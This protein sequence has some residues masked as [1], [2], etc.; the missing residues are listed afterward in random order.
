MKDWIEISDKNWG[1]VMNKVIEKERVKNKRQDVL[2]FDEFLDKA[3]VILVDNAF[4]FD[5]N[6]W[7]KE[8][9]EEIDE[10]L[11]ESSINNIQQSKFIK[12]TLTPDKVKEIVNKIIVSDFNIVNYWKT[13]QFKKKNNLTDEDL[14]NILRTLTEQDYKTNSI[15]INNSKNEAIIFI[16][17]TNI[18]NL[19]G[20]DLYIK[21]DYD[22]IENSPVIVISFHSKK[23]KLNSSYEVNNKGNDWYS[24]DW[25]LEDEDD[26]ENYEEDDPITPEQ[27]AFANELREFLQSLIDNEEAMM[28]EDNDSELEEKFTSQQSL[29]KH[30]QKHCLANVPRRVST[31]D[32]IYYDFNTI[33]RY[34]KY[35]QRM[36]L[37]FKNGYE[38]HYDF[39]NN[40]YDADEV[41]KKFTTLFEGNRYLFISGIFGLRN[42]RGIVH[43]GIHSFSSDVT[44]NYKGGNT[45]DICIMTQSPKTITL[46]PVDAT[47]LKNEL[48]RIIKKYSNIQITPSSDDKKLLDSY[49]VEDN[50]NS[51]YLNTS[52]IKSNG[53]YSINKGWIKH[54]TQQDIPDINMEE[55]EK[56]FKVWE[57]KYFDLLDELE[58]QNDTLNEVSEKQGELDLVKNKGIKNKIEFI[59]IN[60]DCP[61]IDF[62][63]SIENEKLKTKTI[64]NIYKLADLRNK[65]RPPLSEYIDDGIFEL[66]TK[67]SSN[68]TRAFYFFIWG[69]KIVMTNGY[70]KKS[71]KLDIKAFNKAKK[72]MNDYLKSKANLKESKDNISTI[73]IDDY[74]KDCLKNEEFRKAWYS[75]DKEDVEKENKLEESISVNQSKLEKID[76]LIEDIYNLRKE[77]MQE[78]G[79]YSIKNLIFKEFRNL[80]YLDNLKELRK[81][82]ISKDLSLESLK[83]KIMEEYNS[84]GGKEIVEKAM[85]YFKEINSWTYP[86]CYV[87]LRYL[88]TDPEFEDYSYKELVQAIIPEIVFNNT[89]YKVYYAKDLVSWEGLGSSDYI[90]TKKKTSLEDIMNEM[91]EE[92]DEPY[93]W[94]DFKDNLFT[95]DKNGD[96]KPI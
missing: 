5:I 91:N 60:S 88:A 85:D 90:I 4:D 52:Q 76:N 95:I 66:R 35:E 33:K 68:I 80:G 21:L 69:D 44:T 94:D 45:I 72:L 71:Q 31:K 12:Y 26:I 22:S 48:L 57:D 62:I 87:F 84:V 56:E 39:I 67:F 30:F 20:V 25:T 37:V 92:S 65:T 1:Q 55:F 53:I 96:Y 63:N 9:Q 17:E 83:E 24:D 11:N 46:Y 82:E 79:E 59:E 14:K 78:E 64:K 47:T 6:E 29:I 77:G 49:N 3:E 43:L 70:I 86:S 41:N 74:L 54:P 38:G 16:K 32:N 42:S 34:F 18:K 61:M 8:N 75:N 13:N 19:N 15:A 51:N 50:N 81:K 7:E 2:S 10:E 93:T 23:K 27:E 73:S 89:P 40:F 28:G 58:E 36:N